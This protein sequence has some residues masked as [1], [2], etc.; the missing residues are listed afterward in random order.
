MINSEVEKGSGEVLMIVE[1][2]EGASWCGEAVSTL[3]N[4]AADSCGGVFVCTTGAIV[5]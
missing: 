4:T 3:P 1:S 2:V 5:L